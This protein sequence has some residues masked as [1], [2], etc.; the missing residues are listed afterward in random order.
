MRAYSSGPSGK[1]PTSNE[2]GLGEERS[3]D[4]CDPLGRNV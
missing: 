4:G 1:G 2:A 3:R